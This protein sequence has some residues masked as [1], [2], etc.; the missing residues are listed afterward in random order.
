MR[1]RLNPVYTEDVSVR[2]N[3][4]LYLGAVSQIVKR[5]R[6]VA[7]ISVLRTSDGLARGL[8]KTEVFGPKCKSIRMDLMKAMEKLVDLKCYFCQKTVCLRKVFELTDPRHLI[9]RIIC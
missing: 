6:N 1:S 7:F 2:K 4:K 5:V 3:D 9:G 8:A